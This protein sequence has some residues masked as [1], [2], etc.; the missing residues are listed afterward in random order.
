MAE[1]KTKR[2]HNNNGA[3]NNQF[4]DGMNKD[5]VN[6]G[7]VSTIYR[8]GIN[9]GSISTS[10]NILIAKTGVRGTIQEIKTPVVLD[11]IGHCLVRDYLL[12]FCKGTGTI[13]FIYL[14]KIEPEG[15]V[16][17]FTHVNYKDEPLGEPTTLKYLYKGNL[18]LGD[19]VKAIGNYENKGTIKVYFTDNKNPLRSFNIKEDITGFDESDFN[20]KT[21]TFLLPLNVDQISSG[22]TIK[23]GVVQY[24]YRLYNVSGL[25]TRY[26]DPTLPIHI[27]KAEEDSGSRT[28]YYRGISSGE[29]SGKSVVL[30]LNNIPNDIFNRITIA[31]IYFHSRDGVPEIHVIEDADVLS[32]IFTFTDTGENINEE[33]VSIDDAII[34][35]SVDFVCRDIAVKNN[36]LLAANIKYQS[37]EITDEEYDTRAFRFASWGTARLL[38]KTIIPGELE[39]INIFHTDT[40]EGRVP[41]NHDCINP[42]NGFDFNGT[43]SD[44]W[45]ANRYKYQK[46]LT[47][48]GGEGPNIKYSFSIKENV[49]RDGYNPTAYYYG[50]SN[51]NINDN[52]NPT[53]SF[54]RTFM[55]G[56][57]YRLG[58]VFYSKDS[59][60]S[61]TKWIGDVR[62]PYINEIDATIEDNIFTVD[63]VVYSRTPEINVTLTNL[64]K[65]SSKIGGY[66]IVCVER[67]ATDMSIISQGLLW[68]GLVQYNNSR[69]A[70]FVSN[71]YQCPL[72]YNEA[73]NPL[74]DP[75]EWFYG[76]IPKE[77]LYQD[78]DFFGGGLQTY[79][80]KIFR[81]TP[82]NI[83]SRGV[84]QLYFPENEYFG[85]FLNNKNNDII[86]VIGGV[87]FSGQS[88]EDYG[89]TI[90]I[91][92]KDVKISYAGCRITGDLIHKTSKNKNIISVND[93][94]YNSVT[95]VTTKIINGS[96]VTINGIQNYGIDDF[97]DAQHTFFKSHYTIEMDE[98]F[99]PLSKVQFN[100]STGGVGLT[101]LVNYRRIPVAQYGGNTYS[102]RLSN[103]YISSSELVIISSNE[104]TTNIYGDVYF[105]Y[106]EHLSSFPSSDLGNNFALEHSHA[107]QTFFAF[108]C[109]STINLQLAQGYTPFHNPPIDG[110]A[111][112][113]YNNAFP[114]WANNF[115]KYNPVYSLIK[116]LKEYF[117]KDSLVGDIEDKS[118]C[119]VRILSSQE[120]IYGETVDSWTVFKTEDYIDLDSKYGQINWIDVY[121]NKVITAQ[122]KSI[123][124]VAVKDR[125]LYNENSNIEG[126][127]SLGTGDV[128]E[129]YD[130]ITTTSGSKHIF[131]KCGD[132]S[133]FYYYDALNRKIMT[134]GERPDA[135][136][137]KLGLSSFLR[138]V[139]SK[140]NSIEPFR[141]V[142]CPNRKFN[143]IVMAFNSDKNVWTSEDVISPKESFTLTLNTLTGKFDSFLT[144][145]PKHMLDIDGVLHSVRAF[146]WTNLN[147]DEF[148]NSGVNLYSHNY[149]NYGQFYNFDPIDSILELTVN[150]NSG[151]IKVF[152]ALK[153]VLTQESRILKSIQCYNE[154][155]DSG[156]IEFKYDGIDKTIRYLE[157]MW[158]THVPRHSTTQA[159][160][161]RIR[162]RYMNIRLRFD[163]S[164]NGEFKINNI[165]TIMRGSFR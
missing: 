14:F 113:T 130:Y 152:D 125:V 89:A 98:N 31:R 1:D 115:A 30:S 145:T 47:T 66:K 39:E 52:T 18:D 62:M 36:I 25:E 103:K 10:G 33:A 148:K 12:L 51:A 48:L 15:D 119:D 28:Q 9:I 133:G 54:K 96:P 111:P 95:S 41:F 87:L 120:K 116:D 26:S 34:D 149:G 64:D 61:L 106:I 93:L 86:E 126:Q 108:P 139:N 82:F 5:I 114:S 84:A 53:E 45:T 101:L 35:S 76:I 55:P 97:N 57:V 37:L 60:E 129:R 153:L 74:K 77:Y 144:F 162:G 104:S 58:I 3:S 154:D 24:I 4:H 164:L 90:G 13:A 71:Y 8:D 107:F 83:G 72:P 147:G 112:L 159:F 165:I 151:L 49:I 122:D 65:I 75:N 155:F 156:E 127:L 123:G 56:E 143:E 141:V 50:T 79:T 158:N 19:Y 136:T 59:K 105:D 29:N 161:D 16:Y 21:N 118:S 142:F 68:G 80:Y 88:I 7:N 69:L 109:Y 46:D 11:I 32:D 70:P 42:S 131:G 134:I 85:D 94:H 132:H 138:E 124:I 43:E 140:I 110:E 160:K 44:E 81:Q 135:I 38:Q 100:N 146:D 40:L 121:N 137:D 20:I 117:V 102:D 27:V 6:E 78:Y 73:S 150:G 163:N 17:K 92:T 91:E 23:T 99:F 157:N 67:K 63:T 2:A 22:G 128:L